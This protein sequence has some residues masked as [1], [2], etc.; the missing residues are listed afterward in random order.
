MAMTDLER[1]RLYIGD[2]LTST[3]SGLLPGNTHFTDIQLN[4]MILTAGSW[5]GAVPL[6]L[7]TAASIYARKAITKRIGDFWEDWRVVA[8]DLRKQAD[9]FE[10]STVANSS[11]AV[12]FNDTATPFNSRSND[13]LGSGIWHVR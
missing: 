1:V 9:M 13:D 4:E 6:A 12:S 11:G 10:K 8:A 3:T 2:D 7:R 5:Q